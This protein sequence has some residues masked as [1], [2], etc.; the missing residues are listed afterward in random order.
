MVA[1]LSAAHGSSPVFKACA[2]TAQPSL[3]CL[4][5]CSRCYFLWACLVVGGAMFVL[6]NE[7]R[8]S[9]IMCCMVWHEIKNSQK[10]FTTQRRRRRWEERGQRRGRDR[11]VVI[12]QDTLDS[13]SHHISH[14]VCT[15]CILQHSVSTGRGL[16]PCIHVLVLSV[17][18]SVSEWKCCTFC[19]SWVS[20]WQWG[21]KG[22]V[23]F[24]RV[25]LASAGLRG[26]G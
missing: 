22:K 8:E 26:D 14:A 17:W 1:V 6:P 4:C 24:T 21:K 16:S 25:L 23:S 5:F 10:N 7:N 18:W 2:S 20:W 19:L 15:S 12:S 9:S 13:F 3:P 11:D